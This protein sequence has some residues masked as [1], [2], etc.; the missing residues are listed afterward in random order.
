MCATR[1]KAFGLATRPPCSHTRRERG[2]GT[3]ET[4]NSSAQTVPKTEAMGAETPLPT[5]DEPIQ[6]DNEQHRQSPTSHVGMQCLGYN[7]QVDDH[8][9]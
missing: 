7:M 3:P 8:T 2:E 4:G 5:S 9:Q 1:F 6:A